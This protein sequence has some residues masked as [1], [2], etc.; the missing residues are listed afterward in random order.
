MSCLRAVYVCC[1]KWGY[2]MC[3]WH[4]RIVINGLGHVCVACM[5]CSYCKWVLSSVSSMNDFICWNIFV[6]WLMRTVGFKPS[7]MLLEELFWYKPTQILRTFRISYLVLS[8][9]HIFD[10]TVSLAILHC[11]SL[12]LHCLR[13]KKQSLLVLSRWNPV[14]LSK[15]TSV[16]MLSVY[17]LLK[18]YRCK[19]VNIF[20]S[21]SLQDKT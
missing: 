10:V 12:I 13:W 16:L 18:Y 19:C 3:E 1:C 9:V 21:R 2:V 15:E 11:L 7:V 8:H 20:Y 4:Q 14:K 17:T 6:V 5:C